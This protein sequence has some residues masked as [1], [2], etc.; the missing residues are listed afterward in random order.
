MITLPSRATSSARSL[1]ARSPMTV[2]SRF[3][4]MSSTGVKSSEMPTAFN[5]AASA[6]A[7][8]SARTA[9]PLRPSV[10]IDGHTV[11]GALRRA[12]RPP[13]DPC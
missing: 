3:V 8:R 2:L 7:N 6:R 9:S 4:R 12:T 13:S 11:K 5:S 1:I 10:A